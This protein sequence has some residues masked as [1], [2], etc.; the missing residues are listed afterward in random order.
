[1]NAPT[2]FAL[3]RTLSTP[4]ELPPRA[5]EALDRLRSFVA[6]RGG[7]I[8]RSELGALDDELARLLAHNAAR[9]RVMLDLIENGPPAKWEGR[10]KIVP[11]LHDNIDA[12]LAAEKSA[13]PEI[14]FTDLDEG[15]FATYFT[16][17]M[18]NEAWNFQPGVHGT[19]QVL[20]STEPELV[21]VIGLDRALQ[22]EKLS[23]A[24][25]KELLALHDRA[26]KDVLLALFTSAA[27]KEN[28]ARAAKKTLPELREIY[29]W[30]AKRLPDDPMRAS[31]EVS[32]DILKRLGVEGVYS[33]K[34]AVA[35]DQ[36]THFGKLP[37]LH[38]TA[39]WLEE[40]GLL[41][42]TTFDNLVVRLRSHALPSFAQLL[43]LMIGYGLR[44]YEVDAS[45]GVSTHPL[46]VAGMERTALRVDP[47]YGDSWRSPEA[48]AR[49]LQKN[50]ERS[51]KEAAQTKHPLLVLGEGYASARAL[52]D[53]SSKYPGVRTGYVAFTQSGLNFLRQLPTLRFFV[54]SLADALLK[55]LAESRPLGAWVVDRELELEAEEGVR[56][57]S[58]RTAV[59]IGYGD[60]VGPG[61]A[62]ALAEKSFEKVLIV[63]RDPAR[64]EQA[65]RDGFTHTVLADKDGSFPKGDLYFTAAGQPNIVGEAALKSVPDGAIVVVHGSS[66][67]SDKHFIHRARTR[68]IPGVSAR[69]VEKNKLPDHR[70]LELRFRDQDGK[71]V[72][73]RKMGQPFFSGE[74]KDRLL[75]DVYMSGLLAAMAVAA[76]QLK[77]EPGPNAMNAIRTLDGKIQR[78][79]AEILER[80]YPGV[81]F[82]LSE[83]PRVSGSVLAQQP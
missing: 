69:A 16:R 32:F 74:D 67:E 9:H 10:L 36:K 27:T 79:I 25:R 19:G 55:K 28:L 81:T 43:E 73:L 23:P 53:A 46:A 42:R 45:K 57:A 66:V 63:D 76:K 13:D 18:T 20:V 21:K 47:S 58:E 82:D 48:Q 15:W 54:E 5:K 29:E 71:K 14:R 26:V 62:R 40:Q 61:I 80:E 39:T 4:N 34:V 41:D 6:A 50:M 1:M 65:K 7:V 72:R 24:K 56:P 35:N 68:K 52:H 77:G 33:L 38:A 30:V 78:A 37:A 64:L 75:V 59:V 83:T 49:H 44:N 17:I 11:F 12:I 31:P 60:S 2:P 3:L 22:D 8:K 51:L 70:T